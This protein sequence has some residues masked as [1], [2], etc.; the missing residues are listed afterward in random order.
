MSRSGRIGLVV[1]LVAGAGFAIVTWPSIEAFVGVLLDR[2]R[3][4]AWLNSF[5]AWAPLAF[6]AFSFIQTVIAPIP[7]QFIGLASGY[8]FGAGAGLLYGFV[9]TTL[10]SWVAMGLGRRFGRPWVARLIS[11]SALSRF[12]RF[13]NRRGPWFF[14]LVFLFPFVPDDLACYAIGLGPLPILPMLAMASIVR[15]PV[16]AVTVLLGENAA[17]LPAG[18]FV[19]A[20]AGLVLLAVVFWKYQTPIEARLMRWI[21]RVTSDV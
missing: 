1:L 21:M 15:L 14:F 20:L 5:G 19:A 8:L 2:D 9:G 12:D 11:E 4:L 7:G 6:I 3:V 18:M 10:G 13:S 17:N 16:G